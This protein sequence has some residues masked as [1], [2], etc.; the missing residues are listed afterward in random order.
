M[1]GGLDNSVAYKVSLKD[2]AGYVAEW[3]ASVKMLKVD[4]GTAL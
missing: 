2:V 1:T 4:D 3:L